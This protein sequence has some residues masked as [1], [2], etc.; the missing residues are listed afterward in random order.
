M[1]RT[2]LFPLYIPLLLSC[3]TICLFCCVFGAMKRGCRLF[4]LLPCML[5]LPLYVCLGW[6]REWFL[7]DRVVWRSVF[8]SLSFRF[9]ASPHSFHF[10]L[11]LISVTKYP[12]LVFTVA[13]SM[14]F[15]RGTKEFGMEGREKGLSTEG[16]GGGRI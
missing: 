1:N 2:H 3:R 14:W 12:S 5:Y 16:E 13:V 6:V 4:R 10:T 8:L 11:A 9:L 7:A 15:G